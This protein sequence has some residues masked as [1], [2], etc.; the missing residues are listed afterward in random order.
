MAVPIAP[1]VFTAFETDTSIVLRKTS[2][3]I[4]LIGMG[5]ALPQN[6]RY[7]DDTIGNIRE[8]KITTASDLI[9]E[10]IKNC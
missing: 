3:A 6:W 8:E 4:S 2:R 9:L 5:N 10:T 7:R 1:R